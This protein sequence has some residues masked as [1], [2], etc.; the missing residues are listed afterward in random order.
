MFPSHDQGVEVTYIADNEPHK[1][2]FSKQRLRRETF[3]ANPVLKQFLPHGR[4]AV[5][6]ITIENDAVIYIG[7][8]ESEYKFAEGKSN[9][10]LVFDETQ[11][12][13]L[14][15][16]Y[17]AMYTLSETH[18]RFYAFGLGGEQGSS[19][20]NNWD[21]TDQREWIYDDSNWRSRLTF[22]SKGNISN[23]AN[24]LKSILA[25][26]WVAQK[27]ENTQYRGYHIP[28]TIMPSKP[29]T[30]ESAINDY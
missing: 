29:L 20:V 22:D 7:T 5:E 30:I 1:S 21:R 9:Y 15:F 8:D 26:R 6:E 12:H 11:Y 2:A 23:N 14:Q 16:A 17:K 25:G 27:P 18:G 3:L 4:A 24:E 10:V 19:Y 28:Q 13:D